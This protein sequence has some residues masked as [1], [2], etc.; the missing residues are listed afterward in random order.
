MRDSGAVRIGN[1][2]RD[3]DRLLSGSSYDC[4]DDEEQG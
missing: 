2:T 4:Q 3:L 1:Y